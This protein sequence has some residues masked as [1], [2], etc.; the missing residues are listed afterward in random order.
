MPRDNVSRLIV[1]RS[2][3]QRSYPVLAIP[4]NDASIGRRCRRGAR[5][6]KRN[7]G[8]PTSFRPCGRTAGEPVFPPP[9]TVGPRR[10]RRHRRRSV[11]SSPILAHRSRALCQAANPA[12]SPRCCA[13]DK[14]IALPT[15]PLHVCASRRPPRTM[16]LPIRAFDTDRCI[17]PAPRCWP[18]QVGRQRLWSRRLGR[19]VRAVSADVRRRSPAPAV[20][21]LDSTTA[22]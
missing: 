11:H 8:S 12:A 10:T 19:R 15:R 18:P 17:L 5:P 14:P 3:A 1:A 4:R 6:R 13:L 20:P 16:R 7:R 21:A 22:S 9:G 2:I